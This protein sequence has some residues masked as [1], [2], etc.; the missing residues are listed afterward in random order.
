MRYR[1]RFHLGRGENF[2]KWQIKDTETKEVVYACPQQESLKLLECKLRNRKNT[3]IKI[4]KGDDKTVCA[5]IECNSYEIK[6]EE[7]P[8]V[9]MF[10]LNY[11]PRRC[12]HWTDAFGRL[13][14]DESH[15]AE[16]VTI[17]K[18]TYKVL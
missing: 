4:F 17:G 18:R 10:E 6:K 1:V 2:M 16:I 5:W 9:T 7:T 8:L 3:A 15:H 12:V 13:D 14:L 11:N